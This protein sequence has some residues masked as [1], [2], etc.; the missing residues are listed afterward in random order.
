MVQFSEGAPS[1]PSGSSASTATAQSLQKSQLPPF[2]CLDIFFKYRLY[3]EACQ[4]LYYRG[5][6]SEL[7][8]LI[9][10]EFDQSRDKCENYKKKIA[11]MEQ[12]QQ[13]QGHEY[14]EQKAQ[15]RNCKQIRDEWFKRHIE[16]MQKINEL[17]PCATAEQPRYEDIRKA[18]DSCLKASDWVLKVD[19][20]S[21][22]D[23]FKKW[24]NTD[25]QLKLQAS[26]DGPQALKEGAAQDQ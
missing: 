18:E 15:L 8:Q 26:T 5:E 7:L 22:V 23:C 25:A 2:F 3:N 13:Q 17:S 14:D 21:W 16:Y 1:A 11:K 9:R 10:W 20:K 6:H 12:E 19:E 4:F 24:C